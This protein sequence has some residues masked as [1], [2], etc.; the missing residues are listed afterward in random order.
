MKFLLSFII[1]VVSTLFVLFGIKVMNLEYHEVSIIFY[2]VTLVF[3]VLPVSV[4]ILYIFSDD[5]ENISTPFTMIL[6]P[7]IFIL[8]S[9]YNIFFEHT[10]NC[11]KTIALKVAYKDMINDIIYFNTK[12]KKSR[13]DDY[14]KNICKE[15]HFI[16]NNVKKEATIDYKDNVVDSLI[17]DMAYNIN[18]YKIKDIGEKEFNQKQKE[19]ANK[20]ESEIK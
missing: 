19:I 20:L 1:I 15:Y 14:M 5:R 2:I 12:N 10:Y 7:I 18:Y 11:Q 13:D 9:S 8:L 3:I 6:L 4:F 16:E 17:F